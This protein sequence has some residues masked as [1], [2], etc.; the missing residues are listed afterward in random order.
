MSQSTG[1]PMPAAAQQRAWWGDR[2]VSTKI[3][4]AVATA[5]IVA[6]TVGVMGISALGDQSAADPALARP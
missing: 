2:G 6:A 1:S 4:T 3:L 5:G